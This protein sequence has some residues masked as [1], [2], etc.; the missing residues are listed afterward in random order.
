[1]QPK[2]PPAGFADSRQGAFYCAGATRSGQ[3]RTGRQGQQPKPERRGLPLPLLA[4]TARSSAEHGTARA[5]KERQLDKG[6]EPARA[7]ESRTGREKQQRTYK[8]PVIMR[9]G[10]E[11]ATRRRAALFALC[12]RA[13]VCQGCAAPRRGLALTVAR[14]PAIPAAAGV[15][16]RPAARKA[17]KGAAPAGAATPARGVLIAAR[18][19][20]ARRE[21]P[22]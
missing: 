10:R 1:M 13:G 15:P 17:R 22:T 21:R 3:R 11:A 19:S 2:K 9:S 16:P 20:G 14:S 6:T 4:Q 7:A 12:W 8:T 5:Q 18:R